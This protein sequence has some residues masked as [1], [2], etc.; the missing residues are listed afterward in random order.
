V[1]WR[2]WIAGS[3]RTVEVLAPLRGDETLAALEVSRESTLGSI[4]RETGGILVDD[5]WFRLL[6]GGSERLPSLADWAGLGAEPLVEPV[7]RGLCVAADAVGG[8]FVLLAQTNRVHSFLPDSLD[9][10]DTGLSYS[11][12][13]HWTLFGDLDSFYGELRRRDRTD[14]RA[15]E[16]LSIHE[17]PETT[18]PLVE[19][20]ALYPGGKLRE[21]LAAKGTE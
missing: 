20:W 17:A 18:R 10:Q 19:L 3:E 7:D 12:F 8:F 5:A 2:D 13:V 15:D 16:A 6:G 11:Q 14:L 21:L 1:S 4:A 9:W